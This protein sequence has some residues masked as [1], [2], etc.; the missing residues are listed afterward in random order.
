MPVFFALSRAYPFRNR[1]VSPAFVTST[2]SLKVP[3]LS[4]TALLLLI[5]SEICRGDA[6]AGV[7]P[8]CTAQF[9]AATASAPS[10]IKPAAENAISLSGPLERLVFSKS[11]GCMAIRPF[12]AGSPA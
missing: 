3:A 7:P 12:C 6:A 8:V 1:A 9:P 11:S 10:R 2:Q 5:Y 4:G